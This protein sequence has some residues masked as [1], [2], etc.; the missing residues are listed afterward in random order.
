MAK[1]LRGRRRHRGNVGTGKP[2]V[3]AVN[4]WDIGENTHRVIWAKGGNLNTAEQQGNVK[5]FREWDMAKAF[6]ARK[7]KQIGATKSRH[8]DSDHASYDG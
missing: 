7:A 6:A 4:K 8:I 1:L 5:R 2:T 3:F